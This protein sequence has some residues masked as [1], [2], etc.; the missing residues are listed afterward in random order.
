MEHNIPRVSVGL[1]V[2]NGEEFVGHAIDCILAQT[3]RD[4]ELVVSDNASTDRT[5]E[6]CESYAA[7]D[8]RVRYFRNL[9]NI[10]LAPNHNR[11]VDLSRGQIFVWASHDDYIAPDYL[12]QCVTAL[13]NDPSQVLCYARSLDVDEKGAPMTGASLRD[14]AIPG[15]ELPTKSPEPHV[16]FRELIRF[17]HQ[18]EAMLGLMRMSSLRDTSM[19]GNYAD[20][21]RVLLAELGLRGRFRRLPDRLFYHREHSGRSVNLHGNRYDRTVWMDPSN[22]GKLFLP[23]I[24]QLFCLR[25]AVRKAP[26]SFGQAFRCYLHLL[27]WIARYRRLFWSD[28]KYGF[29]QAAK[30]ILRLFYLR[31]TRS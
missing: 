10:G 16:R 19:H 14:R 23:Y 31:P 26:I 5:R 4:F 8:G 13:D 1:P 15:Q 28:I 22:A 6:I 18:C 29:R 12:Q 27:A 24:H 17:E 2:Y 7:R 9:T 30:Q 25:N 3:F 21:D 11:V 20:A